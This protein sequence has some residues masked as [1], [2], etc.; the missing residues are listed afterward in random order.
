VRFVPSSVRPPA[1]KSSGV[2]SLIVNDSWLNVMWLPSSP[3]SA[4]TWAMMPLPATTGS[5]SRPFNASSIA[6]SVG[7]P[8]ASSA[9]SSTRF[10]VSAT[11]SPSRP[12]GTRSDS[13]SR[14]PSSSSPSSPPSASATSSNPSRIAVSAGVAAFTVYGEITTID[15]AVTAIVE[16]SATPRLIAVRAR[17]RRP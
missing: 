16:T 8:T 4:L 14:L 1:A 5:P 17:A 3:T 7:S 13:G 9:V 11:F 6:L 2:V 15:V 10:T 12:V